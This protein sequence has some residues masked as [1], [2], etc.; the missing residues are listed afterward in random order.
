MSQFRFAYKSKID[1]PKVTKCKT[2]LHIFDMYTCYT[3]LWPKA[4]KSSCRRFGR[5]PSNRRFVS[6]GEQSNGVQ[7]PYAPL[8]VQIYDLFGMRCKSV[9]CT[10]CKAKLCKKIGSPSNLRFVPHKGK[11]KCS[12]Q[13]HVTPKGARRFVDPRRGVVLQPFFTSKAITKLRF[14]FARIQI[15]GTKGTN[16]ALLASICKQVQED[17]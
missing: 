15:F 11:A 8:G 5:R 17:L 6:E 3:S 12:L 4:T 13:V 2:S 1:I 16:Q 14:V 9:I 10:W 7:V